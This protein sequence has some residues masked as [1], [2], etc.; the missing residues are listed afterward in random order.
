M[1]NDHA[2]DEDTKPDITPKEER[3]EE[4][5]KRETRGKRIDFTN[6]FE[7][8]SDESRTRE[9]SHSSE[10]FKVEDG[11]NVRDDDSDVDM[12]PTRAPRSSQKAKPSILRPMVNFKS[13]PV[14]YEPFLEQ[15]FIPMA[16]VEEYKPVVSPTHQH[17]SERHRTV[18]AEPTIDLT[19]D[20][21]DMHDV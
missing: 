14:A 6:A 16:S 8:D 21:H 17:T 20:E 11:Q 18:T 10:E 12:T 7:Q 15:K 5:V 1:A 19:G 13:A 4:M 9:W 3:S 2:S